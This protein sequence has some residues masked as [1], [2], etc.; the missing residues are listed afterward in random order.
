MNEWAQGFFGRPII[1]DWQTAARLHDQD[2][3]RRAACTS[4]TATCATPTAPASRRRSSTRRSTSSTT[5]G[6]CATPA[7]RW[8]CTCR[9][10]RPPKKR[11]SG[12]TSCRRSSSTS[13]LPVGTIKVYVLVE[14]VEACFQLMEIRAAL[15]THFVGFNTGRWDYINS[16][17]D[18]MAWDPDVRQ[19]EHRRHHDDLRLHAQLRGPRA[20]RRAT[21]PT[22]TGSSRCGRAAW[23]RTSRSAP[24]PASPAA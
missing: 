16:V 24:R 3:P 18:A 10:S 12:T 20:P 14:Q 2:L 4:T 6:A 17:S 21:R 22:S 11:R 23:S 9:R 5:T 19:P 1:D 8:C 13:G 15:G 7:R